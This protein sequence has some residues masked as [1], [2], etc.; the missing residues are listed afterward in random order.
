MQITDYPDF[1]NIGAATS[2]S[3]TGLVSTLF[4][5]LLTIAGLAAFI[6]IVIGGIKYLTSAGDPSK[7]KDAKN[8]VFAAILGLIILFS[9]WMVLNTLNP[10]LVDIREPLK[11]SF[12]EPK[13]QETPPPPKTEIPAAFYYIPLGKIIDE[14]VSQEEKTIS[15][16]RVFADSASECN[17]EQCDGGEC[18]YE[19]EVCNLVCAPVCDEEHPDDC[20]EVCEDVCEMET[21]TCSAP[22][23]TNDPCPAGKDDASNNV[24]TRADE[25]EQEISLLQQ[26][27]RK[28]QQCI[29]EEDAILLS[30]QEVLEMFDPTDQEKTIDQWDDIKDCNPGYDFYCAYGPEDEVYLDEIAFSFKT[31]RESIAAV[32]EL[33]DIILSCACSNC[34]FCCE[35]CDTCEGTPCASQVYDA[36]NSAVVAANELEAL[37]DGLEE[38]ISELSFLS[39][40]DEINTLTCP[41]AYDWLQFI[42]DNGCPGV[43][44]FAC[45]PVDTETKK[46][47]E[48]CRETDF[49]FCSEP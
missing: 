11:T 30:C 4:T 16:M 26:A 28:T 44:T 42:K 10:Q 25:M 29:L 38:T 46:L 18:E 43:K 39:M 41:E 45:C 31:I 7:T 9:S 27:K 48:N 34:S 49:F 14:V 5:F 33:S 35:C 37:L 13:P 47:I 15:K 36:L 8:Q 40:A 3:L 21:R 17:R 1:L 24:L 12:H 20:E 19:E 2:T 32:K 6:M 22:C 23:N